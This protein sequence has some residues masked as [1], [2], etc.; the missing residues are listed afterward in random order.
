VV[1]K[2]RD[3][4]RIVVFGLIQIEPG[5][6]LPST[7]PD[8]VKGL[9]FSEPLAEASKLKRLRAAGEVLIGLTH[10]GYSQ[11]L[12]LARQ[13]PEID[14]IVGGHSHTRIDP[15]ATVEGVLVAQAGAITASSGGSTCICGTAGS[16][17]RRAS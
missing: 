14:V 15:A 3:G 12:L 4:L 5:N 2:T 10:I 16:S 11:D 8:K 13:W 9:R 1:L 17:R 7:H 6:G